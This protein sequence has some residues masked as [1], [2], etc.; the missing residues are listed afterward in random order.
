MT[1]AIAAG[2]GNSTQREVSAVR[3]ISGQSRSVASAI[4]LIGISTGAQ[5]TALSAS[6]SESLRIFGWVSTTLFMAGQR[7]I[8]T[9]RC[10]P[11]IR[12][13]GTRVGAL[14]DGTEACRPKASGQTDRGLLAQRLGSVVIG[15]EAFDEARGVG[16]READRFGCTDRAA[17]YNAIDCQKRVEL[18]RSV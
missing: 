6:L 16:R 14:F 18:Q 1:T 15:S 11:I 3:Q 13:A 2:L 4:A 17:T 9:Y 12:L 7:S 10:A 8:G 5:P